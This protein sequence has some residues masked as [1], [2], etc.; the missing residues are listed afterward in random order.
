MDIEDHLTNMEQRLQLIETLASRQQH[1]AAVVGLTGVNEA[2]AKLHQHLRSLHDDIAGVRGVQR[3]DFDARIAAE[4]RTLE[5]IKRSLVACS[6]PE[7]LAKN[8]TE[9]FLNDGGTIG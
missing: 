3:A 5:L 4:D 7:E 9:E 6:I 2:M 8:V 1:A